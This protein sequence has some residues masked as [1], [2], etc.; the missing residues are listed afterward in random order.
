MSK[1]L[2]IFTLEGCG[3]CKELKTLVN[4]A[5][6]PFTEIEVNRNKELWNKVVDQTKNEYLPAF[7]IK[8]EGSSSGPFY[9]PERDFKSMEEALGII[10]SYI[11]TEEGE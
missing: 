7:F 9:C 11:K 1:K 8:T 3:H 6:I 5:S 2:M 4:E 10:K